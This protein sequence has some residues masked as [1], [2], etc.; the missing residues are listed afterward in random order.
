MTANTITRQ[1]RGIPVG[2]QFSTHDRGE[3]EVSLAVV[4]PESVEEST[5]QRRFDSVDEKI[6]A[7]M[8]ELDVAVDNLKTDEEWLRYLDVM[9]RFHNYSMNNQMLIALQSPNATRVAGFKKWQE[10]GRQVRK[11]EKGISIMAPRMTRTDVLDPSGNPK[12]NADGKAMK[13]S[14]VVGVTTATVFDVSQ[15]EGTPL[16]VSHAMTLTVEPPDGFIDDLEQAVADAGFELVYEDMAG[17][18]GGYTTADGSK[19]V[20]VKNGMT[21]GEVARTLAHELGHIHAGH[22][23]RTDEYHSGSG[24]CRGQMEVEADSISYAMLRANGMD[25]SIV[26][27]NASYVAGWGKADKDSVKNAANTVAKSVKALLG[28]S[29]WRN[30]DS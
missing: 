4:E 21:R 18:G 22:L 24:G 9:S 17:T 13:D 2:G 26:R 20:A 10:M 14:R 8:E 15:T 23:D 28:S 30:L 25:P 1:P 29:K 5:F 6:K 19:K 7:F 16:P 27:T 11:G 3:A 12:L